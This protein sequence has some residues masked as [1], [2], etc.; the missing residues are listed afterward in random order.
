M[1]REL[2]AL[3]T[4]TK[5]L[6][7]NP[8]QEDIPNEAQTEGS[9]NLDVEIA[10]KLKGVPEK[11]TYSTLGK[12]GTIH[13]WIERV[14][15]GATYWDLVYT[16]GTDTKII[17]DFYGTPAE[18]TLVSSKVAQTIISNN[19]EV[20]IGYG[21][22][23]TTKWAGYI[24]HGQ[25]GG[26][27][28][29]G[30]QVENAEPAQP[31]SSDGPQSV[32]ATTTAT[33]ED[34]KFPKGWEY[35]YKVS[36]VYDGYQEGPLGGGNTDSARRIQVTDHTT[37][38]AV[39]VRFVQYASINKRITGMKV[40]RRERPFFDSAL[41]T[42]Y[43]DYLKAIEQINK[44]PVKIKPDIIPDQVR[45][46][47]GSMGSWGEY[48]LV[49]DI[50]INETGWS[51]SDT[52]H[53]VYTVNDYNTVGPSYTAETGIEEDHFRSAIDFGLDYGIGTVIGNMLF[54]SNAR[55]SR[56]PDDD[57]LHMLFRS[58]PYRYDTFDWATDT[59]ILPTIPKAM[60]AHRGKLYVW[61]ENT[62]YII[63][64]Y[65]LQIVESITGRGCAS[66]KSVVATDYG[67]FWANENGVYWSTTT[68][69]LIKPTKD[70]LTEA[71]K[72]Q[73]QTAV[74][75]E[76]PVLTYNSARNQLL[77]HIDTDIYAYNTV[78]Q[79]WDFYDGYL[80][81]TYSGSFIGKDG[82]TYS[83][84]SIGI[85]KEFAAATTAN[86][87][88]ISKEFT[89]DTPDQI[90]AFY[91]LAVDSSTTVTVS[92]STDGGSAWSSLSGTDLSGLRAT[93][94]MIKV[95][96][97]VSGVTVDSI[98]LIYRRMRGLR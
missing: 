34:G 46:E 88:F 81:G 11:S 66:Q 67:L 83:S 36:F 9:K 85:Y 52:Y 23:E 13:G 45:Y 61:D 70:N 10:G 47:A 71:I 30:I 77:V 51:T 97:N 2:L 73:Y 16:D 54:A 96:G 91:D 50:D 33:E 57:A 39:V 59:L 8:D 94:F 12:N 29:S 63:D 38:I 49:E 55:H 62:T 80:S 64:P 4:F 27:A 44:G 24:S 68:K 3:R 84:T 41:Y 5:G 17:T 65:K 26:S 37:K 69:E 90:K 43:E 87:I 76:T 14:S 60:K 86:W 93:S 21:A 32:T 18:S 95:A 6:I 25:F 58:K 7:S 22:G 40:Y 48:K 89:L 56:L 20:H 28:P 75:G 42:G 72:S 1:P 79:R 98:A 19:N 82:E 74:S 15:S 78:E 31:S 92:Y 53:K 35:E